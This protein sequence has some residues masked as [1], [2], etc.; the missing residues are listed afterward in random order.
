MHSKKVREWGNTA[1]EIIKL[2]GGTD[3]LKGITDGISWVNAPLKVIDI[4][5][6]VAPELLPGGCDGDVVSD[7]IRFDSIDL[8]ESTAG[9]G[10]RY[11]EFSTT[12]PKEIHPAPPGIH[13]DYIQY[14]HDPPRYHSYYSFESVTGLW[15]YSS[16]Y[17]VTLKVFRYPP[18]GISPYNNV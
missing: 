16:L 3:W 12:L 5:K 13:S 4:I 11:V 7:K 1:E 18:D 9:Y 15:K 2:L 10:T 8:Q 14:T 17:T 6:K